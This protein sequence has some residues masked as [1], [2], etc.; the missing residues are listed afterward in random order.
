MT[1]QTT[2]LGSFEG[3]WPVMLTPFT[4]SRD[5]DYPSLGRLIEWYLEAG[6]HGLFANCLS[7][8]MFHLSDAE[9]VALTRFVVEQVDGRVPVVASG[10]TGETV[11]HQ[12]EQVEAIAST[13]V[14]SVILVSNRFAEQG[15]DEAVALEALQ[16]FTAA[17][18]RR[19]DLGVYECPVPY[20]RLLSDAALEW[21]AG[22]GRFTAIKDTCCSPQMLQRRAEIVRNSRVRL[23]NANAQTLLASLRAGAHGYSGVMANF[24][25]YLYVWLVEHWQRA[26]DKA[27]ALSEI[28]SV[29]ALAESLDYPIGA[30]DFHRS[31]GTFETRVCRT[32]PLGSYDA[33]HFPSTVAQMQALAERCVDLLKLD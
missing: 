23:L 2:R 15:A 28:L 32:R 26:P 21:C 10:H 8:E 18:P 20:K 29:C 3:V 11:S 9:S 1:D 4:D 22:S 5:I 25:P 12:L 17:V 16:S 30:K 33:L 13:G 31:I 6:V 19:I 27:E 24:H 7:S 14:A